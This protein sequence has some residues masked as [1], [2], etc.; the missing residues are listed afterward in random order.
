MTATP[1]RKP[2][3]P[4]PTLA[5]IALPLVGGALAYLVALLPP[6]SWIAW[7]ESTGWSDRESVATFLLF[8]LL[9]SAPIYLPVAVVALRRARVAASRPT[10]HL[11]IFVGISLV[12]VADSLYSLVSGLLHYGEGVAQ[13]VTVARDQSAPIWGLLAG[14]L[15][16]ILAEVVRAISARMGI[17][18]VRSW[19]K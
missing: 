11:L 12:P 15:T 16:G 19:P 18:S 7:G 13:A 17:G 1:N 14:G 2:V 9:V 5:W 3:G 6:V 8:E 4:L 10:M